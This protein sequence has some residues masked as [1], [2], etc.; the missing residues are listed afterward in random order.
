[1]FKCPK[2]N[3][4]PVT[5]KWAR[6]CTLCRRTCPRCGE[7]LRGQRSGYCNDCHA[8]Y[9]REN[10]RKYK[11]LS[12][13]QKRRDRCRSYANVYL[14]R[15]KI[16]RKPCAVEGCLEKPQMHHPDYARPLYVVWL[17]R[18]HHHRLHQDEVVS[19]DPSG[20]RSA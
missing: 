1:M 7:D 5:E 9:M 13:E 3:V 17:C 11:D 15:G 14:R 20:R 8:K 6:Y 10:R 16:E 19:D 2:C 4:N 18:K 12:E